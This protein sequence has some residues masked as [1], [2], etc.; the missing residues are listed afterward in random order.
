MNPDPLPAILAVFFLAA[1]IA[2]L[3]YFFGQKLRGAARQAARAAHDSAQR[4]LESQAQIVEEEKR[5]L[6]AILES[7]AEAV[8]V[9]DAGHK[10]KLANSALSRSFELKRG[11]VLG[12]HYWEVFRD[13]E[14]NQM[15]ESCLDQRAAVKKE[16]K[17]SLSDRVFEIQI[18]PVI[19]NEEF[20]GVVAVFHDVTQ[21][22]ALENMRSEFVANVSHELKTPLT[23]I[24]GFVETLKAGASEDPQDRARFLEIIEGHSRRLYELIE[25]LLLLSKIESGR[26]EIQKEPVDLGALFEEITRGFQASIQKN[27][28]QVELQ[29]EPELFW[30]QADRKIVQQAFTNL[31]DNAIKYNKPGGRILVRTHYEPFAAVVEIQDTGIGIPQGDLGRVFERF[32]RVDKSRSRDSGGTGLGLSIVKHAIE[33]HGGTVEATSPKAGGAVFTVRLPRVSL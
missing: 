10:I 7:M 23:S 24:M 9:V 22:K 33:R 32:Y 17:V 14:L 29:L 5:R 4:K 6:S 21:L 1:T 19:S 8:I 27:M 16:H 18:S 31:I 11:N 12:R 2:A 3:F 30:V 26:E 13:S 20:L 15:I 28:I 25:S